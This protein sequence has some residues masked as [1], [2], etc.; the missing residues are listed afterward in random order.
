M[1]AAPRPPRWPHFVICETVAIHNLLWMVW[2]I[3]RS[4]F[5]SCGASLFPLLGS[6]SGSSVG[7]SWPGQRKVRQ[8]WKAWKD[9]WSSWKV[10]LCC[11]NIWKPMKHNDWGN[12]V[13][14]FIVFH[15]FLHHRLTSHDFRKKYYALHTTHTFHWPVQRWRGASLVPLLA[16]AGQ[17][18][19]E[20]E[21]C[22]RHEKA[23]NL[24]EK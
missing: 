24:H 14:V 13:L 17:V 3:L 12:M 20:R 8:V 11:E 10:K 22:E 5:D 19:G 4:R 15:T 7:P 6:L 9:S 2:A 21:K 23:I 1:G 18:N 16:R